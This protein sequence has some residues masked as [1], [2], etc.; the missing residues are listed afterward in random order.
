MRIKLLK[1]FRQIYKVFD[2]WLNF[3]KNLKLK[4]NFTNLKANSRNF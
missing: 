1:F 3:S 2:N 4:L